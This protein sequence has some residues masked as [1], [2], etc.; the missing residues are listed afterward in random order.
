MAMTVT[1]LSRDND[2]YGLANNLQWR[3]SGPQTGVT[4]NVRITGVARAPQSEY[5][6]SFR[7]AG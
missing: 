1:D 6:Y 2:G 7:I 3:V 4:Y 5:S